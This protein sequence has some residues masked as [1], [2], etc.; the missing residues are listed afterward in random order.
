MNS[1]KLINYLKTDLKHLRQFVD[2]YTM[3]IV[4]NFPRCSLG[5]LLKCKKLLKSR[6]SDNG[7]N[8]VVILNHKF[9][10]ILDLNNR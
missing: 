8:V 4:T 7:P 10:E 3:A 1:A 6:H 9:Y 2:P 5:V